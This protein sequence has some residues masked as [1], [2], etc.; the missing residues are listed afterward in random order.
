MTYYALFRHY[1]RQ[2]KATTD[3]PFTPTTDY[4]HLAL[5]NLLQLCNTP[6]LPFGPVPAQAARL[7]KNGAQTSSNDTSLIPRIQIPESRL[8]REVEA[9]LP[10]VPGSLS[11]SLLGSDP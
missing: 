4:V 5:P 7:L 1:W 11:G 9:R 8:P 6:A 2:Y 3:P 10:R